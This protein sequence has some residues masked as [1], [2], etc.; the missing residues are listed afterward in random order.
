MASLETQYENYLLENPE[1][2]LTLEEWMVL[3][4]EKLEQVLKDIEDGK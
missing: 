4:G 2:K 1:S 3:L